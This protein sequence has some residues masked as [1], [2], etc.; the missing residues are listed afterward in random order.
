MTHDDTTFAAV[1]FS[2]SNQ[3]FFVLEF[4]IKHVLGELHLKMP[5]QS[6]I[7]ITFPISYQV[8]GLKGLC[9]LPYPC[10]HSCP[11]AALP[12]RM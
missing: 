7:V 11:S 3:N 10:G 9:T 5:H 2:Q 1:W 4:S 8:V 12:L 6:R